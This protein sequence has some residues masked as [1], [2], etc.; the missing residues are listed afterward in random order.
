MFGK[1]KVKNKENVS[2]ADDI[3]PYPAVVD[4][5]PSMTKVNERAIRMLTIALVIVS[6]VAIGLMSLI[7]A[8]FPLKQVYPYLVTFKEQDNQV[9]AI[10]PLSRDAPGIQFATEA[11]IR[12]YVTLRHSFYPIATKMDAQW[13]PGSRLAVMTAEGEYSDFSKNAVADR[14]RMTSQNLTREITIESVTMIQPDTWQV[15]FRTEDSA[16]VNNG[17]LTT[18]L[19]KSN[20]EVIGK[21]VVTT[22]LNPR[23]NEKKWLATLNIDYTP[24]NVNFENRLL[25]P[26]GFTVLD[27]SVTARN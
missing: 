8:I 24:Q 5:N 12:D 27:Y 21:D 17:G 18:S 2:M 23:I 26:L 16:A 10:E 20:S 19:E 7:V 4:D 25:N 9:V 6:F 22:D 15:A 3:G 14:E 11:S 13:G 1:N